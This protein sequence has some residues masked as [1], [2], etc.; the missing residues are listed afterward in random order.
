[1]GKRRRV[2]GGNKG[3]GL[4]VVKKGEGLSVGKWGRDKG[5]NKEE[6]LRVGIRGNR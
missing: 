1:V 4:K 6:G 2:K 5:G 3:E